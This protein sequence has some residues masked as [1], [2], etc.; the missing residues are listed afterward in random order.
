M[1]RTRV[2]LFTVVGVLCG[3]LVGGTSAV[4][5]SS[6]VSKTD[7]VKACVTKG[8]TDEAGD[9][10]PIQPGHPLSVHIS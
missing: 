6:M 9:C 1:T 7:S 8:L 2:L 10:C 5:A 3:L 4:V